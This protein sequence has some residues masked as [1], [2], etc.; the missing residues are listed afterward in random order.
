MGMLHGGI[1]FHGK[2]VKG[3]G[4]G[5]ELGFP[6]F[7]LDVLD[8][9]PLEYGVYA[10][11]AMVDSDSRVAHPALMHYGPKPTVGRED[12]FC[13]VYFLKF[14][15][16]LEIEDLEVEVLGKIRAVMKFDGLEA[17][18]EQMKKD[19]MMARKNYFRE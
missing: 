1:F 10:V 2:V 15:E 3:M 12:I 8:D 9:P 19:E 14:P 7:N 6:T 13:E 17:L 5:R 16:G 18:V 11:Q 4:L